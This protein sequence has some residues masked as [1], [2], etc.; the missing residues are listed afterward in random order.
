MKTP[1]PFDLMLAAAVLAL[2]LWAGVLL[3]AKIPFLQKFLVPASL[4]GGVI[5]MVLYNAGLLPVDSAMFQA[6]AYHLFVISFISIGL[7]TAEKAGGGSG[8]TGRQVVQGSVWMA[9]QNGFSLSTQVLLGLG[10]CSLL[11]LAGYELSPYFGYLLSL[12]FNQGPG[13]ALALGGAFEQNFGFRHGVNLALTFAALG[14]LFAFGA[15]VPLA[16][17]GVRKGLTAQGSQLPEH[18]LRGFHREDEAMETA[19]KLPVHSG[20]VD[21]FAFQFGAIGIVYGVIYGCFF[22]VDKFAFPLTTA[23]G[24]FFCWALLAS[25]LFRLLLGRLKLMYLIDQGMQRRI[26]GWA[27]DYM[28]M[29]TATCISLPVVWDFIVPVAVIS[30]CGGVWTFAQ[31]YYFGRR[32]APLGFERTLTIYGANTGTMASGLLLL[33]IVDPEFRTTVSMECGAYVLFVIP[34]V[35]AGLV[36]MLY[37]PPEPVRY[38]VFAGLAALCL[39]LLKV[40]KMWRKPGEIAGENPF[41]TLK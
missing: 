37:V 6:I 34:V 17:W 11:G 1:V 30:L 19:G 41:S 7:C 20:N 38:A 40:F 9:L 3:R 28:V 22:L 29:A 23:W 8:G 26:S 31:A 35:T 36:A 32:I 16:R 5:G 21:S 27:V 13:Q 24:F 25:V 4:T 33:R 12:G 10:L 14:F 39:V 18:V 15:G 2:C